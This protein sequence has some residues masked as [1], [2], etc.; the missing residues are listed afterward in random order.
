MEQINKKLAAITKL[1]QAIRTTG[2][3]K[4]GDSFT[5]QRWP[6]VDW[7]PHGYCWSCD[8]KVDKKYNS[9]TCLK[10]KMGIK[11]QLQGQI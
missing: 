10:K 1:I 6:Q 4:K 2:N 3:N 11:M 9:V 5:N 7:D 8:Y